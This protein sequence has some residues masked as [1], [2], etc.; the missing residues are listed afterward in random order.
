[1]G[2]EIT[3]DKYTTGIDEWL[4]ISDKLESVAF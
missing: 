3:I 1:M 4:D 2:S